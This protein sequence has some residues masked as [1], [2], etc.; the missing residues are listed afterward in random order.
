MNAVVELTPWKSLRNQ[1][2]TPNSQVYMLRVAERG[3]YFV[4]ILS[5]SIFTKKINLEET[6]NDINIWEEP[7]TDSNLLYENPPLRKNVAAGTLNQ[8]VKVLT[9][10]SDHGNKTLVLF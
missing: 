4:R 10:E 1:G 6:G 9:S 2:V 5:L 8:L 7:Q 3:M